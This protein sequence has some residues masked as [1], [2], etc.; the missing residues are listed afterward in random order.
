MTKYRIK[1]KHPVY[2][3]PITFLDQF[4]PEQFNIVAFRKG[5]DGKDLVYT[6]ERES[7]MLQQS[8]N[9]KIPESSTHIAGFLSGHC[10][11]NSAT[12]E[13]SVN[14]VA[15]Y[16]RM[17]IQQRLPESSTYIPGFLCGKPETLVNDVDHYYRILV[18]Q[19]S[20]L[21]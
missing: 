13:P 10:L 6:V 16:H 17:L 1:V 12:Q 5:T 8:A 19:K 21:I 2:G 15:K 4:N 18:Q 11:D 9:C 3:V 14:G 20:T 7:R